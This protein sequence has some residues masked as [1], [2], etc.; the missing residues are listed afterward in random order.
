M[1]KH[2]RPIF[3]D[4]AHA[5][6]A[7]GLSPGPESSM[8][9]TNELWLSASIAWGA[10]TT[11]SDRNSHWADCWRPL[12]LDAAAGKPTNLP[13]YRVRRFGCE[14]RWVCRRRRIAATDYVIGSRRQ[15]VKASVLAGN[16][17]VLPLCRRWTLNN[18]SAC[19]VSCKLAILPD[20]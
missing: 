12:G 2:G 19:D 14:H 1:H 5:H 3:E 9:W 13:V 20:A 7:R 17:V 11:T 4:H 8:L 18:A 6:H 10:A 16:L 15:S